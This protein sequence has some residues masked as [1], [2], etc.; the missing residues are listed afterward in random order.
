MCTRWRVY[1][2][3]VHCS[4]SEGDVLTAVIQKINVLSTYIA[5]EQEIN[6]A[7]GSSKLMLRFTCS[8]NKSFDAV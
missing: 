7:V 3:T 8:A 2:L 1:I 5:N 6:S 4:H